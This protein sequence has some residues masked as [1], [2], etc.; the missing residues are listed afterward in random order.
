M[1]PL[2]SYTDHGLDFDHFKK[3]IPFIEWNVLVVYVHRNQ[4]NIFDYVQVTYDSLVI[5]DDHEA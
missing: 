5:I 2:L 4:C 1:S 3:G